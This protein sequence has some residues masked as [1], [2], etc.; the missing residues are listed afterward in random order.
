MKNDISFHVDDELESKIYHTYIKYHKE[1]TYNHVVAVAKVAAKL[2]EK[3]HL[4]IK[5]CVI[6][7]LLHDISAIISADMMY[8]LAVKNHFDLDPA[9]EKY[10][11]LLHQRISKLMAV[12]KFAITDEDILSAIECH[13]TLKKDASDYDMVVFLADKIAWDQD[14]KPPYYD[15]MTDAVNI[16][17]T[18]ACYIFIKYQFDHGCLLMPHQW[19][20]E[21][22]GELIKIT[23]SIF[24]NRFEHL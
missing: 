11:F 13:T 22:Y 8:D 23:E 5:K 1:H 7:S 18:Y 3:Y 19:L 17:L 12:E 6:A 4:D 15:M 16:S 2:A 21:A 10:H 20:I 14:G 9:K 24:Y